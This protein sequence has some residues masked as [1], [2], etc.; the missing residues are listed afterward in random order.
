MHTPLAGTA[1]HRDSHLR[2]RDSSPLS[3]TISRTLRRRIILPLCD[4]ES[5]RSGKVQERDASTEADARAVVVRTL[6]R[7]RQMFSI[8]ARTSPDAGCGDKDRA[9]QS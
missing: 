2:H 4:G 3:A 7:G 1:L 9:S 8:A 6:H 5:L